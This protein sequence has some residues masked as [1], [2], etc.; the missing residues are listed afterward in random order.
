MNYLYRESTISNP[1]E[2]VLV[3]DGYVLV[4]HHSTLC[5][6]DQTL[7]LLHKRYFYEKIIDIKRITS[8]SVAILFSHNKLVQCDLDF[9]PQALRIVDGIGFDIYNNICIVYGR[10]S[11]Q[12]FN[13]RENEIKELKLATFD[14]HRIS[15]AFLMASYVPTVL[16]TTCTKDGHKAHVINLDGV[17]SKI[18]E[19]DILD[20]PHHIKITEM[21]VV[22]ANRNFIQVKYRRENFIIFLNQNLNGKLLKS[23]LGN[24]VLMQTYDDSTRA[25]AIFLENPVVF[26]RNET[27][28]V[29]NGNGEFFSFTLKLEAKR[30]S[31][32]KISFLGFA[33]KPKNA[34]FNND[35]LCV[36][37]VLEDTVLYNFQDDHRL[38]ERGRLKNIGM[39]TG[40]AS[41]SS[42]ELIL[43]SS[44]GVYRGAFNIEV[45]IY[46]KHKLDVKMTKLAVVD[47]KSYCLAQNET[48]SF[49]NDLNLAKVAYDEKFNFRYSENFRVI[50]DDKGILKIFSGDDLIKSFTG[51][52]AWH[53]YRDKLAFLRKG[54]FEFID[55]ETFKVLFST[56]KLTDFENE[57]FN[58]EIITGPE[59]VVISS[60]SLSSPPSR[61]EN[62]DNKNMEIVIFKNGSYYFLIRTGTQLYIYQYSQKRLFKVFINKPLSFGVEK[63]VIYDLQDCIYCQSKR[64]SIIVFKNG[65]HVYYTTVRLGS[66]IFLDG[67]IFAVSKGHL[68]KCKFRDMNELIFSEG[69]TLKKLYLLGKND[70]LEA[71]D[72]KNDT[73]LTGISTTLIN[74][75]KERADDLLEDYREGPMIKRVISL[76]DCNIL[77]IAEYVPFFYHPFIP[78]VHMS[79]GPDGK[80]HSEPINKEEAEYVNKNPALRGR[81]LRYAIELLSKDFKSISITVLE[82][83]E[84]ICDMK[85][86]FK[87]FLAVCTSYPE[88]ENKM[89]KGKLTV[90][91]LANIVPDPRKPHITKKLK[92]ICSETFKYS[93]LSCEEVRSLIAVCIGTKMMIFEFN[94]NTGLTAVGRNE[95]SQLCTSMFV[96]KNLI[97]VSDIL[98][99]IYFF[100]LRPGAPLKLHLLSRSCNVNNCRFLGG[101]D[102]RASSDANLLHLSIISVCKSG[103]IRIFT[104]SPYDP[105][106][107]DGNQLVRRAEIVTQ[108][109]YSLPFST[110]GQLNSNEFIFI[111][112]NMM[113]RVCSI[114]LPKIYT[115]QHYISAFISDR[116]GINT[117]N[118]LETPDYVN[119]EC[120]SVVCERLLLEF[121]Y[122]AP[123]T[124]DKICEMIGLDHSQVVGLIESC[125]YGFESKKA[126]QQ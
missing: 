44:S 21:F 87:N 80:P 106:S 100:F 68:L 88:G 126:T 83:N 32:V 52:T 33:N 27:V 79:D 2:N 85:I 114:N 103:T 56:S 75:E 43:A 17:P 22:I 66:P 48:F 116:C 117:R 84:F 4:H 47:G 69:L 61:S 62:L 96:T 109:G 81:T 104:Y 74:I 102:F 93:C 6:L 20:E 51:I 82:E 35:L 107:K 15:E 16:I 91:A 38:N 120:K 70:N 19:F 3:L 78:M 36:G 41:R 124:Q 45:A 90:Y 54:V 105:V 112:Y 73:M 86:V 67:W 123:S 31:S 11:L 65:V 46:K 92:L 7:N 95:I 115:L 94:E 5:L 118:Y 24:G 12:F 111:S 58:E 97:A 30:I 8:S 71:D 63:Q 119:P 98:N 37:S 18:E 57:I 13:V 101:V 29:I 42:Q 34:D 40:F 14:I 59:I 53:F 23:S 108:L 26:L 10:H 89:T 9:N 28:F 99:G 50:L 125:L 121:F 76:E 1:V 39:I 60:Q 49:D 77:A 110:F 25:R 113:V 72:I 64:P 55:I 122:L